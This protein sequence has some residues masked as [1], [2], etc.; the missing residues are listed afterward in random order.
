M[1]LW[2][3]AVVEAELPGGGEATLELRD[4][5][6]SPVAVSG[7][8]PYLRL[9]GSGLLAAAVPP[10]SYLLSVVDLGTGRLFQRAVSLSEG[11]RSSVR[12]VWP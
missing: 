7:T 3:P 1:P 6:G 11:E 4:T 9:L 10:G 5:A 12:V 2:L 8:Y